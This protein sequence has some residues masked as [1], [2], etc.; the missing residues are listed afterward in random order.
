MKRKKLIVIGIDGGTYDV[1]DPLIEMGAMPTM[2]EL[3]RGSA[4]GIL[5]SV[6]PP[7]TGPAWTALATGY[8]P[9]RSGAYA[10]LKAHK[11]TWDFSPISSRDL[12]NKA[13]WDLLAH[14][15]FRVGI[16]NYPTLYPVY[17]INGFMISG[18]LGADKS[19][20]TYP[21]SLRAELSQVTGDY[22]IYVKYSGGKYKNNENKFI[23]RIDKLL[24]Q[25]RKVLQFLLME[26]K[27]DIFVGVIS[28]SDFIQHYLWKHWDPSHPQHCAGS[29]KYKEEFIRL[30]REI[31]GLIADVL[32]F[33]DKDTYLLLTSDHGFGPVSQTFYINN[34]LE[35]NGFLIRNRNFV[36]RNFKAR[37]L[38]KGA[39]VL[40]MIDSAFGTQCL[41]ESKRFVNPVSRRYFDSFDMEKSSAVC[42]RLSRAVEGIYVLDESRKMEL[43]EKLQSAV[44]ENGG[45]LNIKVLTRQEVYKGKFPEDAPDFFI[46][47]DDFNGWILTDIKSSRPSFCHEADSERSGGHRMEGMYLFNGPDV[48]TTQENLSL[49][50][51]APTILYALDQLVPSNVNGKVRTELFN[52]EKSVRFTDKTTD[53]KCLPETGVD[54][55]IEN[56]LKNLGYM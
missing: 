55:E 39:S 7:V 31:D 52:T 4:H 33:K 34:W 46:T 41:N 14:N 43:I 37:V 10:F 40:R 47:V 19:N 49:L 42:T 17:P 1:I 26:K 11:N 45:P 32:K 35:E 9:W 20:I 5:K 27:W 29:E 8:S 21:D 6:I 2:K 18:I 3:K 15:G 22:Q 44:D 12:Q 48:K 54:V 50:D 28:A 25:N 38:S 16:W 53:G 30:W 13:F 36:F 51:I 23:K 24:D 56:T